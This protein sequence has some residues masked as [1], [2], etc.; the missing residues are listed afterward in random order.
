MIWSHKIFSS[1]RRQY[2]R[3]EIDTKDPI[4]GYILSLSKPKPWHRLVSMS[5]GGFGFLVDGQVD[6]QTDMISTG[7]DSDYIRPKDQHLIML[8]A[9]DSETEFKSEVILRANL[10]ESNNSESRSEQQLPDHS[11][12]SF[13]ILDGLEIVSTRFME[14]LEFLGLINEPN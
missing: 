12:Y 14:E 8:T 9:F 1:D 6:A 3:Y 11:Y 10:I 7:F 4:S 2:P 5:I 13:K